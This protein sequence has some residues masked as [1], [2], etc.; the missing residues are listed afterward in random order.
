M[1]NLLLIITILI[2]SV[3]YGQPKSTD[4]MFVENVD[5]SFIEKE[6]F[7][8]INEHRLSKGVDEL[9]WDTAYSN[10]ARRHSEWLSETDLF[11]HDEKTSSNECIIKTSDGN[12]WF[13]YGEFANIVVNG[14]KKSKGHNYIMLLPKPIYGGVGISFNEGVYTGNAITTF[15]SSDYHK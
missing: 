12:N 15:Q 14:W 3:V 13:T 7:R 1:K 6:I 5:T 11:E 4:T 10:G 8:V 9:E 2:S